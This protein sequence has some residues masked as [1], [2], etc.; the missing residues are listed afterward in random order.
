M[1][2]YGMP[3]FM[4]IAQRSSLFTNPWSHLRL[5]ACLALMSSC[6]SRFNENLPSSSSWGMGIGASVSSTIDTS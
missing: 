1:V 3:S 4:P 5:L 2:D 6:R